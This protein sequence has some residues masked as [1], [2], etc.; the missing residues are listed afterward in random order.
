MVEVSEVTYHLSE[1]PSSREV[2]ARWDE[3]LVAAQENP[4]VKHTLVLP[5]GA[6]LVSRQLSTTFGNPGGGVASVTVKPN[7]RWDVTCRK[8]QI[9]GF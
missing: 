9:G 2:R 4:G 1:N 3:M 5:Q 8:T 6:Y 7:G